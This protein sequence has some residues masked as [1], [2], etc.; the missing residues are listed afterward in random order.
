MPLSEE[1]NRFVYKPAKESVAGGSFYFSSY[2]CATGVPVAISEPVE[3]TE[4]GPDNRPR[5]VLQRVRTA[6]NYIPS[7]TSAHKKN[8]ASSDGGPVV[9]HSNVLRYSNNLVFADNY[10]EIFIKEIL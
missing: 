7:D 4:Q 2:I 1:K 8:R 5:V 9:V 3:R 10:I 6:L